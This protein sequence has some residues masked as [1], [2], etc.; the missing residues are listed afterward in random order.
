M[1]KN[2]AGLPLT[3][4]LGF[5]V[6][7]VVRRWWEQYVK[8]PWPDQLALVM[9][10][11][12]I[13]KDKENARLMRKQIIRYC[14]L[15]YVLC[16]RRLSLTMRER[17]PT[18]EDI[19]RSELM[20]PDEQARIGNEDQPERFGSRW[21]LPLKWNAEIIH[22]ALGDGIITSASGYTNLLLFVSNY[23]S[24]LNDVET[25]GHI[26]VPLV[27]SQVVTLAVYVY[28]AISLIGDQ[29]LIARPGAAGP[30]PVHIWLPLFLSLKFL[31][32]FGWLRVAETLYNPFGDDDEDF[33]M[34][35]L[36]DRHAKVAMEIVDDEE[37]MPPIQK[38]DFSGHF[39]DKKSGGGFITVTTVGNDKGEQKLELVDGGEKDPMI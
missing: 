35:E 33:S 7:L 16:M 26:Q 4:L 5:Y 6:S 24:A 19:V 11:V 36:L 9:R 34:D 31:F 27:Y 8:L 29:T 20:R 18:L 28:F 25:Y 1:Q 12:I 14:I 23:R 30:E 37:P 39:G 21:W 17:F 2:Y 38:D 3:F 22:K 13:E 15:S 32:F 10:G